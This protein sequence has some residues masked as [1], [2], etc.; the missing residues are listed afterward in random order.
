MN[1]RRSRTV[2][3]RSSSF[4]PWDIPIP[5]RFQ[6]LV[7]DSAFAKRIPPACRRTSEPQ[8]AIAIQSFPSLRIEKGGLEISDDRYKSLKRV[9]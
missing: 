1:Q 6:I 7:A 8:A 2:S 4:A 5:G 3:I 9:I